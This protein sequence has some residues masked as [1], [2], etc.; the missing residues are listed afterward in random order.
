MHEDFISGSGALGLLI[1]GGDL[2]SQAAEK[3]FAGLARLALDPVVN[4]LKGVGKESGFT[5]VLAGIPSRLIEGFLKFLGVFDGSAGVAGGATGGR[6]LRAAQSQLGVPYVF[7]GTSPGRAFDCSGL[8]QW[9]YAQAGV[10]IPRLAHSQQNMAGNI[11]YAGSTPGDLVF[12]GRPAHHV[13]MYVSKNRM[14][15]APQP[16][17][18]VQ[19]DGISAGSVTNV[20]RP[21]TLAAALTGAAPGGSSQQVAR[22]L[23]GSYGWGAGEFSPLVNLWNRESGWNVHALNKSSGAYGIPQSLPGNKMASAGADWRDNPVTQIRWGLSYIRNRYGSP[24]AAWAH[25]NAFNWYD[26]GGVLPP[27]PSMVFNGTGKPE[28]VLTQEQLAGLS[29]GGQFTGTLVLE[30]GQFLGVV[31]GEIQRAADVQAR[32]ARY[33]RRAVV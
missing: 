10:K 7:G 3:G 13:G 26:T 1:Q 4:A 19:Y 12:F 29:G 20:G 9:S 22:S 25:S 15:N 11:P 16:G 31:R 17:L 21:Y 24:S 32:A 27:G 2:L 28:A 6:A 23:L 33:G 18:N 5:A 14:I 8:V 30:S